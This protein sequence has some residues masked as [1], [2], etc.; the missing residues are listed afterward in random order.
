M[1][2]VREDAP[3]ALGVE[4]G[5]GS[6]IAAHAVELRPTAACQQSGGAKIEHRIAAHKPLP[7][8]ADGVVGDVC[9]RFF[10]TVKLERYFLVAI[11]IFP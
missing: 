5:R 4:P 1:V 7:Y 6:D 11:V 2:G 8:P 10:E 3:L 9:E